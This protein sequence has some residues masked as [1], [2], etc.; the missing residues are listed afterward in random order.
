MSA[1][2]PTPPPPPPISYHEVRGH[3]HMPNNLL[4]LPGRILSLAQGHQQYAIPLTVV[5]TKGI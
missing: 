5:V 2:P 1:P 3:G 4:E